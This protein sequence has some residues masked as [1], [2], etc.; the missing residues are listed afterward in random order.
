MGD[1]FEG[2]AVK[3]DSPASHATEITPDNDNDLTNAA[4]A[5]YVGTSGDVKVTTVGGDT[6]TFIG[7][8]GLLPIRVARVFATG[9]D[10]S[11]IIAIW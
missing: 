3:L 6:V 9:T 10:A 2:Y 5:L 4:R 8:S 1:Y 7:V 11:N